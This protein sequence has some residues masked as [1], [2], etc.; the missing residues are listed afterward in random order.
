LLS[1][2]IIDAMLFETK[3]I[4][5]ET[6]SEYLAEVRKNLNLTLKEVSDKTGIK[7]QF[8]QSLES[9]DFKVLPADVYV[10]GFLRQLAQ[11]YSVEA[12]SLINQYKKEKG[13]HK[14]MVKQADLLNAA[15]YRQYWQKLVI[16]PKIVSLV[17]GA[18]FIVLTFGYIIWQV[19]SINKTPSL[20]I[21]EPP[22]N[23]VIKGSFV[24]VRG[25][26]DPGLAVT[27]NDQSIFVDDKGDFQ[28]QLG[29]SPGAKQITITAKNRFNKEASQT[30]NITGVSDAAATGTQLELKLDFNDTVVVGLSIDDGQAQ[31][32]N[33]SKGDSKTFS[34]QNKILLST[35]NAGATKVTLN[36]QSVG[37]LGKPGEQLNN[38]PFFAQSGNIQNSP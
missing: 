26:T 6:L 30:L 33:F 10:L 21:F 3:K 38:I 22:N 23:A 14:Q 18:A 36:G 17:L 29:L 19:W 2:F 1:V 31:T 24:L 27:V 9:G 28:N 25:Q 16:T 34:A 5:I 12:E 11:L 35:S 37:T 32:L 7:P 13:I 4:Q 20:Q 8:L 15:W